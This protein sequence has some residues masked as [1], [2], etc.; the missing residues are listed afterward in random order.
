MKIS[1]VVSIFGAVPQ[2]GGYSPGSSNFNMP[3][4]RPLLPN[5]PV[6]TQQTEAEMHPAASIM[7]AQEVARINR[8]Q[9][10]AGSAAVAAAVEQQA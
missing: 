4:P 2:F 8:A 3:A 9:G 1:E 7:A 5:E 6:P 10:A